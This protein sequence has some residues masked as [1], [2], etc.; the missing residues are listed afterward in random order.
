MHSHKVLRAVTFWG[1][2]S[3]FRFIGTS[4]SIFTIFTKLIDLISGWL[5]ISLF[6]DFYSALGTCN[7]QSYKVALISYPSIDKRNIKFVLLITR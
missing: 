2:V 5:L 4:D 1:F 6:F 7:F 3:S